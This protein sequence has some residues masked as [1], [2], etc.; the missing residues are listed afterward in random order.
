MRRCSCSNEMP[1]GAL[2]L[3]LDQ[4]EDAVRML[5]DDAEKLLRRANTVERALQAWDLRTLVALNI[6]TKRTAEKA[7]DVIEKGEQD[8]DLSKGY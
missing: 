6:I 2:S 3:A 8:H 4:A 5:R 1:R 7:A